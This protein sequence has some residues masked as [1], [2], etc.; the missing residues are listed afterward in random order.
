MKYYYGTNGLKDKE[1]V[2]VCETVET[3]ISFKS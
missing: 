3:P 1:I 2:Q